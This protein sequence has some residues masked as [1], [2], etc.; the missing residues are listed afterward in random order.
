MTLG[1]Y[2]TLATVPAEEIG[3]DMWVFPNL[4][5]DELCKKAPPAFFMTSEFDSCKKAAYE[6]AEVFR[7]N[8][9]LLAV[10]TIP[11]ATHC[12]FHNYA[13]PGSD[14]WFKAVKTFFDKHL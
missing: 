7:R 1:V 8:D 13:N 9:N 11:G 2:D 12:A 6:G 3:D 4:I 5:T 14:A 10:G